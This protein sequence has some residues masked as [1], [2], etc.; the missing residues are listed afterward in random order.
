MF[1]A[2]NM[3]SFFF[4]PGAKNSDQVINQTSAR[5]P[6]SEGNQL[7]DQTSNQ[8]SEP[9]VTTNYLSPPHF[10][11]VSES[12]QLQLSSSSSSLFSILCALASSST[13][14]MCL[15]PTLLVD[16]QQHQQHQEYPSKPD[17]DVIS[18]GIARLNLNAITNIN[19]ISNASSAFNS[20]GL[21][22]SRPS[23][24][25][26]NRPASSRSRPLTARFGKRNTHTKKKQ[27]KPFSDKYC[28]LAYFTDNSHMK[29]TNLN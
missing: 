8:S 18:G 26:G 23:S 7:P 16:L 27:K 20:A 14:R 24:G 29:L 4:V 13:I 17:D 11:T 21:Q 9:I 12:S 22:S 2:A 5:Q 1:L 10:L 6:G 25:W 3:P 15:S 19:T 28:T